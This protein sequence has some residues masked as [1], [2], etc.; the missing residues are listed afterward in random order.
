MIAHD[1]V[2]GNNN[3]FVDNSAL[4]GHV[5]LG[6]FVTL[7]GYTFCASILCLGILFIHWYGL[8]N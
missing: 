2:L 7:G 8:I 3:I 6:D 1:C 4:A 5:R